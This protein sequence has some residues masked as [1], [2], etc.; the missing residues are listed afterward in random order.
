VFEGDFSVGPPFSG[1]QP[2][3]RYCGANSTYPFGAPQICASCEKI[4]GRHEPQTTIQDI[5]DRM[6]ADPTL[7][8]SQARDSMW[9]GD[10]ALYLGTIRVL[11]KQDRVAAAARLAKHRPGRLE[12]DGQMVKV[13]EAVDKAKSRG[14]RHI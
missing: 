1:R 3:C 9:I 12:R 8:W 4:R 11:A 14:S 10:D 13:S 2:K 6:R 7:S 5:T